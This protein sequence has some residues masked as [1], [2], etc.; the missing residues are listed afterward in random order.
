MGVT[1]TFVSAIADDPAAAAAGQVLPSHWNAGHTVSVSMAEINATGTP[2]ASNFLRGDGSWQSVSVSPAGS[3]T[4]VQFNDGGAFGAEAGFAYNKTTNTLAVEKTALGT[5]GSAAGVLTLAG[6]TS[7]VVTL[8]TAAAAGTYSL[9]LPTSDGASGEVL[10]TDGAG[11]LSW[12]AGGG[13]PGGSTTQ[14]Q[15]NNAGVFGGT[16]GITTTGTELTIASGTKTAS[17]PVLDITQ[18][19]NNAAVTFTGLK[20]NVTDTASNASSLLMDLQVGGVSQA[21]FSKTGRMSAVSVFLS[22]SFGGPGTWGSANGWSANT[23]FV[24]NDTYLYRDAAGTFAQRNGT[25]AQTFRV[26]NTY[27]DASNYERAKI[28]WESNILKIGT[29][30]AGTGSTRNLQLHADGVSRLEISPSQVTFNATVN[31]ANNTVSGG[32]ASVAARTADG[33]EGSSMVYVTNRGATATVTR[34]LQTYVTPITFRR[35][36]AQAFRIK[37]STG[38]SFRRL[39][40]TLETADKYLELASVGATI[41]VVYDGTEYQVLSEAGTI[42]V[43]P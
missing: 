22:G 39:N 25:S 4:F 31:L 43:E 20:A 23:F 19:W 42:T 15:Y 5:A 9:T 8:Q 11:V 10:T 7:G 13:A 40:G 24:I 26:Y 34:T 41:L 21:S 17:T 32:S 18:T 1:H 36:E 28:A 38:K 2:S 14:L 35:I 27:T 29:E 33:T 12:A 30:K 3:D 16:S 37:P 6:S